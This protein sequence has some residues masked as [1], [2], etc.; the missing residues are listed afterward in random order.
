MFPKQKS[1]KTRAVS[2]VPCLE[3]LPRML[4]AEHDIFKPRQWRTDIYTE[5][6]FFN[7][8]FTSVS[9]MLYKICEVGLS[10]D[11]IISQMLDQRNTNTEI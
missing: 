10:L 3:C 11:T 9:L 5:Y 1:S 4:L 6:W 7:F 2:R 8:C